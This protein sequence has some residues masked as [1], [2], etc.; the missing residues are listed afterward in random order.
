ML[1]RFFATLRFS[2][3]LHEGAPEEVR[4]ERMAH[5][6]LS[7]P[8]ALR[9]SSSPSRRYMAINLILNKVGTTSQ[10]AVCS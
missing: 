1:H 3:K 10:D 9:S 4:F 8:R 2:T 6:N 7:T 5:R